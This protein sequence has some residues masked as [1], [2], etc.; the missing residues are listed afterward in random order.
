M[1][2][3][4]TSNILPIYIIKKL[5][6]K[7]LQKKA[8]KLKIQW[9]NTPCR[10]DSGQRHQ[11][12][13]IGFA[14]PFFVA[15]LYGRRRIRRKIACNFPVRVNGGHPPFIGRLE[16]SDSGQRHQRKRIGF[17]YPFLLRY[18][19]NERR[20]FRFESLA[21]D[22]NPFVNHTLTFPLTGESPASGTNEKG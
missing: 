16:R 1:I 13:R 22:R 4:P 20:A 2:C 3:R 15:C 21:G 6:R 7:K 17:A 8:T 9:A 19:R 5:F 14:Y 12:K 10:F 11:R 18:I